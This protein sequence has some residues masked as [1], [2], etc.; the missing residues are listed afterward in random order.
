M[1]TDCYEIRVRHRLGPEMLQSLADLTP[2]ACDDGTVL[3]TSGLDQPSL[4]GAL[5]RLG[6]LGLEIVSVERT[7]R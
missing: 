7:Q 4:H 1:S 5:G 3:R 6:N 2:A